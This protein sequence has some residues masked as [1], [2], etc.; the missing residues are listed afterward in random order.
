KIDTLKDQDKLFQWAKTIVSN[1]AIN[2]LK[3]NS[4]RQKWL[5]D[6][7]VLEYRLVY[8]DHKWDDWII[9]KELYKKM[10]SLD[11][12]SRKM[13]VYKFRY[14][15]NDQWIADA[16]QLPLGTVKARIHRKIKHMRKD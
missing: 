12:Q 2:A 10:D 15:H 8:Y 9:V 11:T 5:V 16:L 1:T 13:L 4:L 3:N 14:G 7:R 6:D